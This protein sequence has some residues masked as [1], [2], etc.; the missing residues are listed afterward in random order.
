[1]PCEKDSMAKSE[2]IKR[3][4]NKSSDDRPDYLQRGLVGIG[5]SL[6]GLLTSLFVSTSASN[7]LHVR[8]T[9]VLLYFVVGIVTLGLIVVAV[10]V[11]HQ[12]KNREVALLRHRLSEIYLFALKKSALNPQTHLTP[13][14]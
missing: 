14:D 1:M 12:R 11:L 5:V 9:N 3:L 8:I 7:Q 10:A 4:D 6:F 13:H 2:R